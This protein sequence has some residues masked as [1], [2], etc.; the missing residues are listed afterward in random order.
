MHLIVNLISVLKCV[1]WNLL[2]LKC[3][4]SVEIRSVNINFRGK[5]PSLSAEW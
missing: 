3:K 4:L 1:V 5:V 2:S